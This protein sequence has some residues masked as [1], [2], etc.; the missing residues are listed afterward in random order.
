MTFETLASLVGIPGLP[1]EKNLV[2]YN[3]LQWLETWV[4]GRGYHVKL[5]RS[6]QGG[7]AVKK[8]LFNTSF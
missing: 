7:D 3:T 2:G 8:A 4:D 1:A 6:Q 5:K